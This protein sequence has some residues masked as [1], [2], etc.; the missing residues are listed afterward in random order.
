MLLGGARGAGP[1]PAPT[2]EPTQAP[3]TLNEL[4]GI[5]GQDLGALGVVLVVID[6]QGIG[7][8]AAGA[9][10]P[11]L[12]AATTIA[13]GMRLFIDRLTRGPIAKPCSGCGG[14]RQV[15]GVTCGRCLGSGAEP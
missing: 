4:A 1:A 9:H 7:V 2:G 3:V 14:R 8:G 15:N 11:G 6:D 12:Q 10:G 13:N 5:I